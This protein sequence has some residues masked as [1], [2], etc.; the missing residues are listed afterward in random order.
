[1]ATPPCSCGLL[2]TVGDGSGSSGDEVATMEMM[3][4]RN[5]PCWD[6]KKLVSVSCDESPQRTNQPTF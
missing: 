2:A 1:V 5:S 6:P 4:K 3:R